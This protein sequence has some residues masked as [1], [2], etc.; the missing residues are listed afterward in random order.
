MKS[1]SS[2]SESPS[3]SRP[4]R[5]A[6]SGCVRRSSPG[7][8]FPLV[9]LWFAVLVG[10]ATTFAV[11]H[12]KDEEKSKAPELQKAGKEIEQEERDAPRATSSTVK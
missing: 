11:L 2:C 12:G 7:R 9:I 6:C 10:A 1:F 3:Q 5:S 8:A 4:W